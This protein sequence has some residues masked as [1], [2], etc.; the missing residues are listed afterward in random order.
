MV[1]LLRLI[2]KEDELEQVWQ[3][4][5]DATLPQCSNGTQI[6]KPNFSF[7]FFFWSV[8]SSKR[9]KQWK[10]SSCG[11]LWFWF[12]P[13]PRHCEVSWSGTAGDEQTS[14]QEEVPKQ[15]FRHPRRPWRWEE[16]MRDWNSH[17]RREIWPAVGSENLLQTHRRHLYINISLST[18]PP[19]FFLSVEEHLRLF[20]RCLSL[21]KLVFKSP[22]PPGTQGSQHVT[23][24]S[25]VQMGSHCFWWLVHQSA[26]VY[27]FL[28][29]LHFKS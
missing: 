29:L 27:V 8:L 18:N 14:M 5:Q 13:H 23:L 2:R 20:S 9:A 26:K 1:P 25:T 17:E 21:L 19:S 3:I 10:E 11:A 24:S 6:D 4:S 7:F 28:S 16:A 22:G 15:H 12:L